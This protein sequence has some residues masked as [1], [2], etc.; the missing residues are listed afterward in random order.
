MLRRCLDCIKGGNS[1]AVIPFAVATKTWRLFPCPVPGCNS[2][3]GW[4]Q[5]P[6]HS[7]GEAA[8]ISNGITTNGDA[9]RGHRYDGERVAFRHRGKLLCDGHGRITPAGMRAGRRFKQ[10]DCRRNYRAP[11]TWNAWNRALAGGRRCTDGPQRRRNVGV[12]STETV[13]TPSNVNSGTFGKVFGTTL[14]GQL[15]AQPL[16]KTNVNVTAGSSLGIHN[17]VYAATNARQPVRAG[18]QH[19]ARFC[20]KIPSPATAIVPRLNGETVATLPSLPD[21]QTTNI[22]PEVGILSMPVIDPSSNLLFLLATTKESRYKNPA[23]QALGFDTHYVQRLFGVDLGS[24][25]VVK[26]TVV[27]DTIFDSTSF[28]SFTGYQ[29]VAGPVI[30]G[31]G[32]NGTVTVNGTPTQFNDGWIANAS[33]YNPMAPGANCVQRPA[34]NESARADLTERRDLPRLCVARR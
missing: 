21:T 1:V 4:G 26:Q 15:Y 2:G 25:A 17:V 29:Y 16:V 31:T 13:L 28:T 33:G 3:S 7:H 11:A 5:P 12:Y 34:A 23:N 18:C 20:G 8:A 24:G 22:S 32:N 10:R 19:R 27:G 30:N 6:L 9:D 14:D